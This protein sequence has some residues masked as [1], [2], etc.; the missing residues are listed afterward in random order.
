MKSLSKKSNFILNV[1]KE[2]CP[3]CSTGAVFKQDISI[4]HLPVMNDRCEKCNYRFEKEP[5]YFIGAMYISY[6]LAVLQGVFTFFLLHYSIPSISTFYETLSVIVVLIILGRK[7]YTLS[8]V[9]YM[10]IFPW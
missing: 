1:Y 2:K 7:N 9:L 10:H 4:L 3:K 5:G 8:R 6:G